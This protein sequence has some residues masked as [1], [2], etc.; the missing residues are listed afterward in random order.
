MIFYLF[1]KDAFFKIG[2]LTR[3]KDNLR[4]FEGTIRWIIDG[5]N[6]DLPIYLLSIYIGGE[7]GIKWIIHLLGRNRLMGIVM[8]SEANTDALA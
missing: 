4:A 1:D 5:R 3:L 6:M 7:I 8:G 2:K